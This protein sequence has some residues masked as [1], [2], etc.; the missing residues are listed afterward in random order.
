MPSEVEVKL[1]NEK[2]CASPAEGEVTTG[3]A[4]LI[5]ELTVYLAALPADWSL[6]RLLTRCRAMIEDGLHAALFYVRTATSVRDAI[7]KQ[8]ATIE[9]AKAENASL[10]AKLDERDA[11]LWRLYAVQHAA[12]HL[13]ESSEERMHPVH[14][15]AVDMADYDA[16]LDLVGDDH[17]HPAPDIDIARKAALDERAARQSAQAA[18]GRKT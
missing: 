8:A 12:W 17:P 7:V 10:R 3:E 5:E 15:I 6:S 4:K 18:E 16:L 14:E 9:Q 11:E 1:S 13:L 2:G